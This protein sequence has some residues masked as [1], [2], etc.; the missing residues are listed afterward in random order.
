MTHSGLA[1][2]GDPRSLHLRISHVAK[3][4]PPDSDPARRRQVSPLTGAQGSQSRF[5][6][7]KSGRITNGCWDFSARGHPCLSGFRAWEA[8]RI[9]FPACQALLRPDHLRSSRPLQQ[10]GSTN[11]MPESCGRGIVAVAGIQ[12][13]PDCA[14]PVVANCRPLSTRTLLI[15]AV[16]DTAYRSSR[17]RPCRRRPAANDST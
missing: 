11:C 6:E 7:K 8:F 10:D 14:V 17:V 9:R 5:A 4:C 16:S 15:H 2:R 12:C 3:D 1:R 13:D